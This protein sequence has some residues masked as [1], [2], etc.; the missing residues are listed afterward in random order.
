MDA[1]RKKL[2]TTLARNLDTQTESIK[3]E[4]CSKWC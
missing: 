2:L 4:H 1:G 3:K